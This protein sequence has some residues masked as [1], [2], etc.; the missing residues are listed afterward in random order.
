M[1]QQRV[2]QISNAAAAQAEPADVT[3]STCTPEALGQVL[4]LPLHGT[5]HSMAES[6]WQEKG[7]V[8][9]WHVWM[10]NA[11]NSELASCCLALTT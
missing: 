10:S 7:S 8:H 11:F 1:Q 5:P 9:V 3:G 6:S 2:P 4:N